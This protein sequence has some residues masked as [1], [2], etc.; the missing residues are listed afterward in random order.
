MQGYIEEEKCELTKSLAGY[1]YY[2]SVQ[3]GK[4]DYEYLC[5]KVSTNIGEYENRH[6]VKYD[7]IYILIN[8]LMLMLRMKLEIFYM[9]PLRH[10]EKLISG[11][12][13]LNVIFLLIWA[14][15]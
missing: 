7:V 8:S 6:R 2:L 5:R 15:F 14:N 10:L 13:Q 4:V 1:L 11:N 9:E 12:G 3:K